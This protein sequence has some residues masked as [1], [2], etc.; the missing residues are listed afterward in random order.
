MER[1]DVGEDTGPGKLL[2]L[3]HSKC[4]SSKFSIEAIERGS[5]NEDA[6]IRSIVT[7]P[8]VKEM[9]EIGM[10]AVKERK[11]VACSPDG[12]VFLHKSYFGD[13]NA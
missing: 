12:I 10:V 2:E 6:L 11:Y 1:C 4:F 3:F 13:W 7:K 5:I 8:Y 9:F